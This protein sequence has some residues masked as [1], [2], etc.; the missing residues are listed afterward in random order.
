[1]KEHRGGLSEARRHEFMFYVALHHTLQRMG[2]SARRLGDRH[3][4]QRSVFLVALIRTNGRM[5]MGKSNGSGA[6]T[7]HLNR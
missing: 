2:G 5:H 6:V 7:T 1:M 4:E 3:E